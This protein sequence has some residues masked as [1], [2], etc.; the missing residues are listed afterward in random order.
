MTVDSDK[1]ELLPCPFCGGP[2]ALENRSK[3]EH[4]RRITVGCSNEKCFAY[5]P[6]VYFARKAE[7]IAAWNRRIPTEPGEVVPVA[8]RSTAT[9]APVAESCIARFFDDE[10]G[11][12]VYTVFDP[13]PVKISMAGPYSEWLPLSVFNHPLFASPS[14]PLGVT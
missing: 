3:S 12:W 5:M 13:G 8:W 1:T 2:A 6:L 14:V 11:E 7:A 4:E 9:D 10:L